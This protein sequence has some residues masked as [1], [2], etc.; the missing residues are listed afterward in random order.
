MAAATRG[1]RL[2]RKHRSGPLDRIVMPR[3]HRDVAERRLVDVAVKREAKRAYPEG[4]YPQ[5]CGSPRESAV[6]K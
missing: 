1:V 2:P 5:S 4:E 3:R 6:S